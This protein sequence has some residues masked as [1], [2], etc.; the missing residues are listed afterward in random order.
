MYRRSLLA[1]SMNYIYSEKNG[2]WLWL[3]IG[4]R[5]HC[6]VWC[7]NSRVSLF[8]NVLHKIFFYFYITIT[9]ILQYWQSGENI[10]IPLFLSVDLINVSSSFF[11]MKFET[12]EIP[13]SDKSCF[14]CWVLIERQKIWAHPWMTLSCRLM[15]PLKMLL[16]INMWPTTFDLINAWREGD[17]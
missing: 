13:K 11:L 1:S 7:E 14:D 8:V 4:T 12:K 10:I 5:L 9:A 3:I 6:L 17:Y 15:S 16:L 2:Q